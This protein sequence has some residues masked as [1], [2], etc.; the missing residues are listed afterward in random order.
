MNM[1]YVVFVFSRVL[2]FKAYPI[3][4]PQSEET[5]AELSLIARVPRQV[6]SNYVISSWYKQNICFV[7]DHTCSSRVPRNRIDVRLSGALSGRNN[8]VS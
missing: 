7:V 5:R 4:I 8:T 6:R 3:S 2:Y 1:Q